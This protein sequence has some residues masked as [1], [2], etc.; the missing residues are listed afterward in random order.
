LVTLMNINR[1]EAVTLWD[2]GSHSMA[3]SPAFA[4]ILK[5]LVSWL[6]NPVVL[7]LGTVESHMK[8]NFGTMSKVR[9]TGFCG[10]EYFDIVNMDKYD[11]IIRTPFMHRN[12]VILNFDKKQVIINRQPIVEELFN[13]KEAD[14]IA[15]R[16]C[17]CKLEGAAK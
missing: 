15:R 14:R 1:L 3:M 8:I 2:S 11:V 10:M 17:L 9:M 16:Y 5:V 12:H 6:C 7:Q 13:G 4:D